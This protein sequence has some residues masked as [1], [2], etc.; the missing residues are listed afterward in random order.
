M[1]PQDGG[2]PMTTRTQRAENLVES[3]MNLVEPR[4]DELLA[5]ECGKA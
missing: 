5:T 4:I 3:G 2:V 1:T